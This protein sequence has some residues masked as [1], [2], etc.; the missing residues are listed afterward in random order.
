M[1]SGSSGMALLWKGTL[2]SLIPETGSSQIPKGDSFVDHILLKRQGYQENQH[3]DPIKDI[4]PII[5][6]HDEYIATLSDN[7]LDLYRWSEAQSELSWLE[8]CETEDS[9][10]D[11]PDDATVD[12]EPTGATDKGKRRRTSDDGVI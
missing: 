12:S 11:I 10:D 4:K 1:A 3:K 2:E 7:E 9:D 5:V 8:D 6:G